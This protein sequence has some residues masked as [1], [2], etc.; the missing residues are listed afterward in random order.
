MILCICPNPS[1]DMFAWVDGVSA[2][3]VNRITKEERFPGGKAVHVALAITELGAKAELLAVWGGPTGQ[4]IKERCAEAGINCYG[5]QVND[6]SRTC[7]TVKSKDNYHDTELLG[8]GP[9]L[10]EV[11]YQQFLTVYG[12][13]LPQCSSVCMSGSWPHG[14]PP[15]AYATL[16]RMARQAGRTTIVDASGQ[17]LLLALDEHPDVVHVNR[18]EARALFGDR[19]VRSCAVELARRCNYALVTSG[20]EGLYLAHGREVVH[21]RCKIEDVY[22]AVGSGDCLVAGFAL[23]L[24]R[25]LSINEAARLAVACGAANC[26]RRDLGML[27]RS[28]VERLLPL[29]KVSV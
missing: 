12:E 29:V 17:L 23:A 16:I 20:A 15:D 10:T 13:L 9:A 6:W 27:H 24:Q 3:G 21:A 22:S 11:G 8:S 7:I 18:S 4:W 2:G 14:S 25:G 1:I 26:I 28:D 5:P 19:D